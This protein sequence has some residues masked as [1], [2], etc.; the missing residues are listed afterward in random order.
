[1]VLG[2]ILYEGIDLSYHVLKLGYNGAS[3][4]YGYFWGGKT[5]MTPEEMQKTIDDLQE[6][7][8]QLETEQ[9]TMEK[10]EASKS[11]T[12]EEIDKLRIALSSR[13]T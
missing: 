9:K 3:S 1:M 8:K 6:K 12:K 2:T 11:F 4:V 10:E 7:I 13:T 5:E